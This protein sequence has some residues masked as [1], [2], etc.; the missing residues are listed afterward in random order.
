MANITLNF[1]CKALEEW[2][3]N[4]EII[5]DGGIALIDLPD[6][7]RKVV[8]GDGKTK[9]LDCKELKKFPKSL[10][11]NYDLRIRKGANAFICLNEDGCI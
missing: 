2:A 9:C 5:G 1:R 8:I 7:H 6:G 10:K 3:N 4:N 11:I